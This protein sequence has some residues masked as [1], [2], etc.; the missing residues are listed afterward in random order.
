[1]VPGIM[2]ASTEYYGRQRIIMNDGLRI[3]MLLCLAAAAVPA[4]A[5]ELTLGQT[6]TIALEA[7]PRLDAARAEVE[8]AR[9]GE[10]AAHAEWMPALALSGGYG[11]FSGE[12]LFNRFLPGIPGAG[13]IDV[14]PYDSNAVAAVTLEQVLYD[15]GAISAARRAG[16][17]ERQIAGQEL[18]RRELDLRKEVTVA[19]YSVLLAEQRI[20][21]AGRG[22]ERSLEGLEVVRRRHAE[23]EALQVELL[24]AESQLAADRLAELT[25]RHEL[26]LARRSLNRLLGRELESELQLAGSLGDRLQVVAEPEGV[27]RAVAESPEAHQ[28]RLGI[29]R[30]DA[31]RSRASSLKKPKLDLRAMYTRIDNQLIFDGD[32]VGA[33]VNLSVPFIRDFKAS[34]AAAGRAR[35][36]RRAAEGMQR[37]VESGLR[38]RALA[39]YRSLE[40][41]QA[42]IQV[43]E[44]NLEFHRERHRVTLSAYREQLLTYDEVLDHHSELSEAELELSTARFAARLAEAE[45]NRIVGE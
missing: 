6:I 18:L 23:R 12:V 35:A 15:G 31:E 4:L 27:P 34:S 9:Q 37:D 20:E 40:Q 30:A 1:M 10:R 14:G 11:T 16:G 44:R 2:V 13:G 17:V 26:A 28:A 45:V 41:A 25:A 33:V 43:A 8:A 5:Q 3:T 7:N 22:I 38:L 32:Y 39:A 29:D 42:A 21:V 36:L 24:G 19:F